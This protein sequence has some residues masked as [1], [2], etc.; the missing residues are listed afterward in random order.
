MKRIFISCILLFTL[1]VVFAQDPIEIKLTNR[2]SIQSDD[3]QPMLYVYP[4]SN[5]NGKAVIACPGGAYQFLAMEHEGKDMAAW[6][7]KQ[8]IT[9]AVLKYQLPKGEYNVPLSNAQDAIKLMKK[10]ADAWKCNKIGI[11][12]FSA[13]GHL[14]ST[15]A[16]HFTPG[17]RPDFQILFYPVIMTDGPYAH[18]GSRN[19]LMGK[20]AGQDLKELYS[21]E[22]QVTPE[23]PPAFI[24]H[25]SDDKAVPVQNSINYYLSLISNNVSASLHIYPSGKHGWGYRDSFLYKSQW[26]YELEQWLRIQ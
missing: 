16:T 24:I 4:A 3:N 9:F 17:T 26:M 15:V 11:M 18:V 2:S 5:G 1:S 22:K 14:A 19:N 13:G 21:N 20:N 25:C 7:N 8:G 12:G 23:T 10:N 6:F